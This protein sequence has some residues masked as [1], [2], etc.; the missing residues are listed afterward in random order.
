MNRAPAT[1]V[2]V[3]ADLAYSHE[4]VRRVHAEADAA[5]ALPRWWPEAAAAVLV[6]TLALSAAWPWGFAS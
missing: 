4:L 5:I 3:A 6:I 2:A 1:D